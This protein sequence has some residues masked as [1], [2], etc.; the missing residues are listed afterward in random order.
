MAA[1][2]SSSL[3]SENG[4][5]SRCVSSRRLPDHD[6]RRR[7]RRAHICRSSIAGAG[8]PRVTFN[9][10]QRPERESERE[11]G[12]DGTCSLAAQ[13]AVQCRSSLSSLSMLIVSHLDVTS[14]NFSLPFLF[15]IY[16]S[17]SSRRCTSH[18][19]GKQPHEQHQRFARVCGYRVAVR[20]VFLCPRMCA[21]VHT[22]Q[23]E[24]HRLPLDCQ[25]LCFFFSAY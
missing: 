25:A 2:S 20:N 16:D 24:V 18:G 11:R 7:C 1:F 13:A 6:L 9:W 4:V 15:S 21:G 14:K 22:H 17:R 8:L 23:I 10:L 5:S 19:T 3:G 12:A